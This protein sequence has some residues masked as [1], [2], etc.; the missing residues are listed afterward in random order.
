[1]PRVV[2]FLLVLLSLPLHA[3][4]PVPP[5]GRTV[6]IPV[7][8]PAFSGDLTVA[9]DG[10]GFF[11]ATSDFRYGSTDVL[12]TR[13]DAEGEPID[14]DAF[15]V[16]A[17]WHHD[18]GRARPIWN[19][20]EYV[21]FANAESISTYRQRV[22]RDATVLSTGDPIECCV[23]GAAWNGSRYA[24][25]S[26]PVNDPQ[27]MV[28]LRFFD[29]ALMPVD[30]VVIETAASGA[31]SAAVATDGLQF[32]VV[33]P[34]GKVLFAQVFD[35]RGAAVSAPLPL[36]TFPDLDSSSGIHPA[37]SWNGSTYAVAWA[38]KENIDIAFI[39]PAGT[40]V[41]RAVLSSP[42]AWARSVDIAWDGSAHLVTWS[43]Q[44]NGSVRATLLS[45]SGTVLESLELAAQSTETS[46]ASNGR[47]FFVATSRSRFIVRSTGPDRIA[48]PKPLTVAFAAQKN[49]LITAGSSTMFVAW[50]E[51]D[52]IFASR[53]T[54]Q[55][56][57]LDGRGLRLGSGT[58]SDTAT[59]GDTHIAVW[60][61]RFARV[62]SAG[63]RIDPEGGAPEDA[64]R[65]ASNGTS[66]LVAGSRPLSTSLS[67][68]TVTVVP[69]RGPASSSVT[70]ASPVPS[71]TPLTALVRLGNAYAL[72]WTN[73]FDPPCRTI[74]CERRGETLVSL[75]ADDGS[76][77]LSAV[78]APHGG[79]AAAASDGDGLLVAF[80]RF[81]SIFQS[82]FVKRVASDLTAGPDIAIDRPGFSP[83]L[84]ATGRGFLLV[85]SRGETGKSQPVFVRLDPSGH[86][87]GEPAALDQ[88]VHPTDVVHAFGSV[89]MTVERWLSP[90]PE[91]H[92][93]ILARAYIERID[94]RRR[95]VT[96]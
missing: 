26:F 42:P 74:V 52:S 9:S 54:P 71:D 59:A 44:A 73:Y 69:Q 36:T 43:E 65:V 18:Q 78:I 75:I 56:E 10:E 79:A 57:P 20:T 85:Y 33:W 87:I 53:L 24:A 28:R 50:Q 39:G 60:G 64:I 49:P 17:T 61:T 94:A 46:V 47:F 81:Q 25:V 77:L 22:S 80:S 91:S 1:M 72:V 16:A 76:L 3:F 12:G 7:R 11:L 31:S 13:F 63:E 30:E 83:R 82:V 14:A 23:V 27:S 40:E 67:E 8:V 96:P 29:S 88:S 66:F 62:T 6:G 93:G 45:S 4:Q 68:L 55:A 86:P 95:V 92:S 41:S 37:I 5:P 51:A 58:P 32:L 2:P 19:G 48:G 15:P 21:V 34:S 70:V 90:I 35:E 84:A 89:W 38:N